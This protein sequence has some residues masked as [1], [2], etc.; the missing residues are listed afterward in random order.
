[1]QPREVGRR[2]ARGRQPR[3]QSIQDFAND[4]DVLDLGRVDVA[5]DHSAQGVVDHQPFG[6]QPFEGFAHGRAT[7]GELLRHLKFDQPRERGQ[8]ARQDLVAQG[9]IHALAVR[10]R[11][12]LVGA[13]ARDE[14]D[15]S[16]AHG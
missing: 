8:R 7:D 9:A 12:S 2:R 11:D 1:M 13:F 10:Y 14:T 6:N 5:H 3:G 15:G 16:G 4:V